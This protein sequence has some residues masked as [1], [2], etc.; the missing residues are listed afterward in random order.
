M[1]GTVCRTQAPAVFSSGQHAEE[2]EE[3]PGEHGGAIHAL[4]GLASG[5]ACMTHTCL[6]SL[7]RRLI[8]A[9]LGPLPL[10]LCS[11]AVAAQWY[12]GDAAKKELAG[13]TRAKGSADK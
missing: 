9:L 11:G 3:G 7:R 1:H 10:S 12:M 4:S 8:T 2:I 6:P 5:C 13:A